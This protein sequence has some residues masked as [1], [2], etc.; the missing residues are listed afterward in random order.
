M[1][2][3]NN[4][5]EDRAAPAGLCYAVCD[6][7]DVSRSLYERAIIPPHK[8]REFIHGYVGK[9]LKELRFEDAAISV[10]TRPERIDGKM[11]RVPDF[12]FGR[13]Q[14]LSVRGT[15]GASQVGLDGLGKKRV[16]L[17]RDPR[18]GFFVKE[19]FR[20]QYFIVPQSV[21]ESWGEQFLADLAREV[22]RFYPEGGG[23]KPEVI[24]YRDRGPKT[25][26]DQGKAILEAMQG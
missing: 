24:T 4:R 5:G 3:R 25:Y 14:K 7:R 9:Y 17:L 16:D 23:Y 6:N 22:D 1:R 18:A 8:R 15:P 2:Y 20:P 19:R 21:A 10:S 13:G 12:E 11:F 26:R